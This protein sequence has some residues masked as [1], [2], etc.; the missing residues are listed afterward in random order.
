VKILIDM[1]FHMLSANI[2]G[3]CIV[4]LCLAFLDR[5][6][7][8]NKKS[9]LIVMIFLNVL[10][11]I[12]FHASLWVGL[13]VPL[14]LL[15]KFVFKISLK[16]AY[17]A[18]FLSIDMVVLLEVGLLAVG[19]ALV[20]QPV[21]EIKE[22]RL[23]FDLICFAFCVIAYYKKSFLQSIHGFIAQ[24]NFCFSGLFLLLNICAFFLLL[25]PRFPILREWFFENLIPL[26]EVAF[27]SV[28]VIL[29]GFGY[30]TKLDAVK[31][32]SK[33]QQEINQEVQGLVA[34]IVRIQHER[35]NHMNT[36]LKAIDAVD[37]IAVLRQTISKY[38]TDLMQNKFI[39]EHEIFKKLD[40]VMV[41]SLIISKILKA[42]SMNIGFRYYIEKVEF[43]PRIEDYVLC[44]IIGCLLDNAFEAG[45]N[46]VILNIY[47]PKRKT[48]DRGKEGEFAVGIEVKN[49][50]KALD[51]DFIQKIFMKGFSTK[52]KSDKVIRGYGLYNL[53]VIL[54]ELSIPIDVSN[55][56]IEGENYVAFTLT[57]R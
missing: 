31:A 35:K 38:C 22:I 14:V 17:A 3:I 13:I 1:L 43:H 53:S 28:V 46:A 30:Q 27:A 7:L 25:L 21:D 9:I 23:F 18:H 24:K 54:S 36:I 11:I 34:Q 49:K 2:R 56:F 32:K 15:Y 26:T 6:L 33:H 44:E 41:E 57:F 12:G 48:E 45:S 52:P 50:H 16:Q 42:E 10:A 55:D 8:E 4:I 39:K 51:Y 40:R 47:K 37:D 19:T 5:K 20:G 29:V